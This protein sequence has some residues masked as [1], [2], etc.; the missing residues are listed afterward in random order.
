MAEETNTTGL[1]TTADSISEGR[2]KVAPSLSRKK[3]RKRLEKVLNI[4]Y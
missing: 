4:K 2:M 3:K 1:R